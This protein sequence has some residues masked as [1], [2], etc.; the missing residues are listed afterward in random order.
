ME[1][2]ENKENKEHLIN[3]NNTIKDILGCVVKI[4]ML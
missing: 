3:K 1:N 4:K 2:K